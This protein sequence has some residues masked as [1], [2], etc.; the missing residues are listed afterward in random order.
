MYVLYNI[1]T[2]RYKNI[3]IFLVRILIEFYIRLEYQNAR[4][5][6]TTFD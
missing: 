5:K 1:A 6:I 4:M 3:N 2:G